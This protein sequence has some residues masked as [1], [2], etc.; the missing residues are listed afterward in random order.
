M[1][2]PLLGARRFFEKAPERALLHAC[3]FY[4][5][6]YRAAALELLGSSS[7]PQEVAVSLRKMRTQ[8]AP[9][10]QA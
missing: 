6:I 8:S 9:H 2:I 7:L 1:H 3:S 4:Q 5:Y 10:S